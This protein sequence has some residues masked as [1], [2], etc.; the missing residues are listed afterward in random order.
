MGKREDVESM[1]TQV[2]KKFG[3]LDILVNN[4]GITLKMP[5]EKTREEEWERIQNT[6]LKS[7]F[8]CSKSALP[9]LKR[10]KGSI[11]NISSI[12]AVTTT[13]NFSCYAASKGGMEALTRSLAVELGEH[14]IRVNA[15]RP[16]WIRVERDGTPSAERYQKMCERIPLRRAGKTEDLVSIAVL[17]SSGEASYITGQIIGV[18]GGHEMALNTAYPKGQVRGGVIDGKTSR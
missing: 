11:L 8:L 17:L 16:G 10:E 6:N 9:F 3:K 4:A 18:D 5:F 7:V 12:H 1:F 14:G 15:L 2:K 13:F